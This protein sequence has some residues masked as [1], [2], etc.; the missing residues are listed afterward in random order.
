M[1]RI[2]TLALVASIAVLPFLA[3]SA[4]GD[5][6]DSCV[7]EGY[8]DIAGNYQGDCEGSANCSTYCIFVDVQLTA[9]SLTLQAT[10][11]M[12]ESGTLTKCCSAFYV[13][14]GPQGE[15]FL[16][17]GECSADDPACPDGTICTWDPTGLKYDYF[18][19]ECLDE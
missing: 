7:L 10:T 8:I 17:F 6:S 12:C 14:S 2:S 1:A 3:H 9:G 18:W 4:S 16:P 5:S 15:G 11:C 13:R 19:A